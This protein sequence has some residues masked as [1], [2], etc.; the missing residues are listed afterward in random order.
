M[1][2]IVER[3]DFVSATGVR[4]DISDMVAQVDIYQDIFDHYMHCELV[5]RD[6]V[7][8][9]SNA[10]QDLENMI[11]GGF[12]GQETVILKYLAPAN[13]EIG[14]VFIMYKRG[15]RIRSAT[16]QETYVLTGVSVEAYE[17]FYRKISRSYGYPRGS[18]C[19]EIITKI[20][21]ENLTTP[22][23]AEL[24]D[25][26]RKE[27]NL[28][29]YKPIIAE[30]TDGLHRFVIP[31]LAV[32]DAIEFI[33]NE[34]DSQDHIAQFLFFE[35]Y[36][37]FQFWNLS[38]LASATPV[39]EYT[40]S[41]MNATSSKYDVDQK[42]ILSYRIDRDT[43]FLEKARDGL[44]AS[45]VL[46]LDVHRKNL[47]TTTFDYN[48]DSSQFK[49]MQPFK[50]RGSVGDP[51]VNVT[52]MTTRTTHDPNSGGAFTIENHL[53]K[54]LDNMLSARKSY[55]EH[56]FNTKMIVSVPGTTLLNAGDTVILNFPVKQLTDGP[57]QLEPQL[58]GKYL[59]TKLHNLI[60]NPKTDGAF[61]TRFECVKDT[62]IEGE[63]G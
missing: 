3:I 13:P 61:E 5:V 52:L 2:A 46:H 19:S 51:S 22:A 26:I 40:Y 31:N 45:K 1:R 20:A 10:K 58:S 55:T 59:I 9:G 41:D 16:G 44:F 36:R 42:K 54:R 35:T 62:Q 37:G 23:V 39:M 34:A 50:H 14:N 43:N 6:A 57:A 12:S 32:D 8:L 28:E 63:E 17:S 29:I 60:N 18:L 49:K 24:Y 30:E 11:D 47:K 53:P 15:N 25:A 7:N 33:C 27:T 38:T 56:L 4:V 48:T 21:E